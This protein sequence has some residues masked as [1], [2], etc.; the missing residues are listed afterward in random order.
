M[1]NII[2]DLHTHTLASTHAY[3]SLT[4]VVR[5]AK[6]KGLY[7]VAVTDHGY[8]MPG[9]LGKWYF[10]NLGVVPQYFE[11]VLVL[12]GAE[13]NLL[14][15][16]ARLDLPENELESLDW[17]VASI[18]DPLRPKDHEPTVEECTALWLR[19]AQNPHIRVIG[20]SGSPKYRYDYERVI[21]EFGRCGKLVEI[22]ENSFSVR[23]SS[24]PNCVE[25]AKLCKKYGVPVVVNSD[26]HF[27]ASVGVFPESISMLS[28]LDFPRELVINSS[29]ERL[30]EYL[31]KYTKLAGEIGK[32]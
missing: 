6:A 5:A 14:D 8:A 18:H 9:A 7:A 17:V 21:P 15:Y 32:I 28:E 3:S 16:S 1:Y 24:I 23:K 31:L 2:A 11:G 10:S 20:H 26:A 13:A 12:R 4:E 25:I 30:E 19:A 27:S 29:R 22:N